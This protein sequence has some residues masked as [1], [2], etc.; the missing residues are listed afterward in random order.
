MHFCA[1]VGRVSYISSHTQTT[2]NC[3]IVRYNSKLDRQVSSVI[4][5]VIR[6]G[7]SPKTMPACMV[8]FVITCPET[9]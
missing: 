1:Y 4:T 3:N 8:W 2:N 9:F 6:L 5:F 7:R